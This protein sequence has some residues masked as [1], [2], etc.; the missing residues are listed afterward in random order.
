MMSFLG[1]IGTLMNGSGLC[2]ALELC[3]GP[4]AV[5]HMMSGKH[6]SRAVRG[7][8]LADAAV[9]VT[10]LKHILPTDDEECDTA[11]DESSGTGRLTAAEVNSLRSTFNSVIEG[12][13]DPS[14]S[15]CSD[16]M[17]E[18]SVLLRDL[19]EKLSAE[20]R[21]AKLWLLYLYH[22]HT[23]KMFN[24]AKRTG[25]WE[26]HLVAV[27]RMLNLFAATGH[28]Q[29]ARCARLY[30][31]MI[32]DLP[33]SH[34]WLHDQLSIHGFH[35]VRRSDR[36]WSGVWTDLVIEQVLMRAF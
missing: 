29:Y 4:N 23:L 18:V 19:E 27:S 9:T 33:V 8:F 11:N 2:D 31:Q 20:S 26:L 7:H 24:H 5:L 16:I 3:Y 1:S 12:Q 35:T 13:M 22:M 10:L 34:P 17:M 30:L 28:N 25:D 36:Y 21:T 32:T 6:V 15:F 14:D